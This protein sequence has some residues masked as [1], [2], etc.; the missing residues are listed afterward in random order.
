MNV[1]VAK[2]AISLLVATVII[3]GPGLAGAVDPD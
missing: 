1:H 2:Y 3:A